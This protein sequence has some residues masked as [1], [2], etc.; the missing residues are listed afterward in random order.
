VA[1]QHVVAERFLRRRLN[2]LLALAGLVVAAPAVPDTAVETANKTAA[3]A[4]FA[5][6]YNDKSYADAAE[7]LGRRFVQHTPTIAD[8]RAGLEQY[9]ERLRDEQPDSSRQIKRVL[10]DRDHVVIQSHLVRNTGD[11]GA[12][13]G[14]IFRIEGGYVVEHWGIVHPIPEAPHADNPNDVFG[15]SSAPFPPVTSVAQERRNLALA[16]GFY[17]A[18]LNE[19]NWEKA[20]SY[21]GEDYRQ[22]SI[23]MADGRA[24]FKG[25][26]D[27]LIREFPQN[28]GEIKRS[29]ADGDMVVL[30]L[31]VTRT[32]D[33]PGWTVIE[34]M[35]F[36]NE[37]VVEHWDI[38]ERVPAT[39]ANDNTL[40]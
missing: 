28:L 10:T 8:G 33:M 40:W 30:H 9:I 14:D 4:L 29:F 5:H 18:A 35:R 25:L 36:E 12:V 21:I 13:A 23:Y 19:K 15:T 22:H 17:N 7:L 26:V 34:L 11:R 27:R 39:S 37:K 32:R 1:V 20:E 2:P 6:I 31:H 38:F 16:V 24:G 3:M